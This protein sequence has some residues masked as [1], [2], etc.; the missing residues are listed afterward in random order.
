MF[1]VLLFSGGLDSVALGILLAREGHEL[2]PVYLSHRHGGNVTRKEAE[3]ASELAEEITGRRLVIVK[4][5]T[6]DERRWDELGRVV[7]ETK[8]KLPIP[9]D[10]KDSR[11]RTFLRV[12]RDVGIMDVADHVAVGILGVEGETEF[13]DEHQAQA[14]AR[15]ISSRRLR[16]VSHEE[17]EDDARLDP[18]VLITPAAMG[19][20]GKV[21]LL[22]AVGRRS[23]KAVDQLYRSESCL[24]YFNTAC[25]D[26]ASCK[27]RAQAFMAAWGE[28][29]TR[30]RRDTFAWRVQRGQG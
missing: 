6:K 11:N 21:G 25:G 27:S 20:T 24:M 15:R 13:L 14:L 22:K 18:G 7:H 17:L 23:K 3:T 4:A 16:D 9:K 5:V 30:Y 19:I 26:C 10:K 28:D 1:T 12:L 29:R 2:E 8:G